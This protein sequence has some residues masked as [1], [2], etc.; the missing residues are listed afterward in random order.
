MTTDTSGI[1]GPVISLPRSTLGAGAPRRIRKQDV[2]DRPVKKPL[3]LFS[4]GKVGCYGLPWTVFWKGLGGADGT[5]GW[6]GA[7]VNV[8]RARTSRHTTC[9]SLK[10]LRA[11]QFQPSSISR[12]ALRMA[13]SH[14]LR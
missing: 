12:A 10:G 7:E 2:T 4:S 13:S 6:V 11:S 3:S 1:A 5:R 14:I 9:A 8:A